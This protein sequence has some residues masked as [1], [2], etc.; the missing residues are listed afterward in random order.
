LTAEVAG[1][2]KE[3]V[4]GWVMWVEEGREGFETGRV[5]VGSDETTC[6]GE[7]DEEEERECV[8]VC[9]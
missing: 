2:G 5:V 3:L 4:R 9:G 8:R 1:I 7:T 6:Q